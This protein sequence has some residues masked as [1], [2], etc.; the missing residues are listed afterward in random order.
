MLAVPNLKNAESKLAEIASPPKN[1]SSQPP[2]MIRSSPRFNVL[3]PGE[4]EGL[5]V[6]YLVSA[7]KGK[8]KP[9]GEDERKKRINW[10]TDEDVYLAKCYLNV[11]CNSEDG[12]DM[13]GSVFEDRIYNLFLDGWASNGLFHSFRYH[14]FLSHGSLVITVH[15]STENLTSPYLYNKHMRFNIQKTTEYA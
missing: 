2:P 9:Q 3:S 7:T 10:E 8:I 11:T 1:K 12:T 6:S 13:K 14:C 4:A 5:S 15:N